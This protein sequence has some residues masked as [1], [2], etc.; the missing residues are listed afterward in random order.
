[1]KYLNF[2]PA[3]IAGYIEEKYRLLIEPNELDEPTRQH[4]TA[5]AEAL[6][7]ERGVIAAGKPG[8]GKTTLLRAI[9]YAYQQMHKDYEPETEL[10]KYYSCIFRTAKD[11]AQR[12]KSIED[13]DEVAKKGFV[14]IDDLGEEPASMQHY[15]NIV[16]PI[17]DIIER[18]YIYRDFLAIST[19]LNYTQIADKYGQRVAERLVE[20]CQPI[21]FENESYRK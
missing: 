3:T 10:R 11:Y 19:N 5:A 6:Y 13:A 17:V 4:I 15:G 9:Y 21:K 18:K 14:Y 2:T 16:T 8:N 12:V 20:M 1:M 7:N